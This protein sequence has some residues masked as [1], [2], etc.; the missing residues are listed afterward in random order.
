[1]STPTLFPDVPLATQVRPLPVPPH[2]WD[3][4][5]AH[6]DSLE[7]NSAAIEVEHDDGST[8]FAAMV[9]LK[10]GW[11]F[12]GWLNAPDGGGERAIG[13]RVVKKF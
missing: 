9:K 3:Q 2:I 4:V 11:S 5:S 12:M 10:K 8:R 1:M 7:E 6:L 13:A